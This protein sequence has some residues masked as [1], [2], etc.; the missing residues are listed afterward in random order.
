MSVEISYD[1]DIHCVALTHRSAHFIRALLQIR[2]D[3]NGCIIGRVSRVEEHKELTG[4]P[5]QVPSVGRL[6]GNA[7]V[8]I[9]VGKI[10]GLLVVYTVGAKDNEGWIEGI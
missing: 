9:S 6:L 3:L 5:S 7:V 4:S 2:D 8:G 1:N 10:S